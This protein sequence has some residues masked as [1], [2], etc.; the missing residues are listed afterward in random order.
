[1]ERPVYALLDNLLVGLLVPPVI[2]FVLLAQRL[3]Q[4]VHH[5]KLLSIKVELLA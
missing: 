2:P 5:V 1:M 3:Q 4:L